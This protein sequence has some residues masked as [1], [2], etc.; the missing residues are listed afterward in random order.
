M[1]AGDME[2]LYGRWNVFASSINDGVQG[3]P[4]ILFNPNGD[5]LVI[6]QM[7]QFLA[8]SMQHS[9]FTGGYLNYGIMSGVNQVP[10]NYSA[11]FLVFYSDKGVNAVSKCCRIFSKHT[12]ID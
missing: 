4:L 2:K 12:H 7:S 9:K 1:M 6:S 10:A 5:T 8:T 11:D 3:G